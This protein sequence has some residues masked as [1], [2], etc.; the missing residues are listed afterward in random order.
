[1]PRFQW[2]LTGTVRL[3]YEEYFLQWGTGA[4]VI[5]RGCLTGRKKDF[6]ANQTSVQQVTEFHWAITSSAINYES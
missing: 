3:M 1:M 4:V 2:M 6:G 5:V